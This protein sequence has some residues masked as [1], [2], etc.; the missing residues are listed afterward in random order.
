MGLACTEYGVRAFIKLLQYG[1]HTPAVQY[2]VERVLQWNA[3]RVA[4]DEFGHHLL[5]IFLEHGTEHHRNRCVIVFLLSNWLTLMNT[6]KGPYVLAKVL[7]YGEREDEVFLASRLR[8][9]NSE[10]QAMVIRALPQ[11]EEVAHLRRFIHKAIQGE[12]H[13]HGRRTRASIRTEFGCS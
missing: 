6:E 2:L 1:S 7:F 4:T 11:H 13:P 9:L 12:Y 5:E 10:M 3:L 8:E